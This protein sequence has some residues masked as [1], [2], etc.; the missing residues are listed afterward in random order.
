MTT[1][2]TDRVVE[3]TGNSATTEFSYPFKVVATTD[4]VVVIRTIA[5]G[6]EVTA[7]P[8]TYSVV[9]NAENVGGVVTYPLAG[10]PIANTVKIF[11]TS[12][13]PLTQTITVENQQAYNAN[14]ASSVWDKLTILIQELADKLTRVPLLPLNAGTITFP[15]PVAGQV[16]VGNATGYENGPSADEISGAQAAANAAALSATAAGESEDLA[17]LWAAEDEDTP[18]S[19]GLFSALHYAAKA[20]AS[21]L[22][23]DP[24]VLLARDQQAGYSTAVA[25][26]STDFH[27]ITE[28]GVY[29]LDG[30]YT[31]GPLGSGS[32]AYAGTLVVLEADIVTGARLTQ[33]TYI[34]G[35]AVWQQTTSGTGPITRTVWARL[36]RSDE[37]STDADFEED[38]GLL[39]TRGVIDTE[40]AAQVAAS[41]IGIGQTWQDV[42][43]S[44]VEN[45]SYQNL[46]GKPITVALEI[47]SSAGDAGEFQ[48]STD[49]TTW[50]TVHSFDND[51]S[52][53][54][55]ST[56]IIPPSHYYRQNGGAGSGFTRWV[57]L[58]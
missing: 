37:I 32:F 10:S 39:T 38:T 35:G 40:I 17:A 19:G 1:A 49:D 25:T 36:L 30:N 48:V 15:S 20:A 11:I 23:N 55:N 52:D 42:T 47:S 44:R 45:T 2:A 41:A 58:R 3:Y 8:S 21:A 24:V 6:S 13:T 33:L 31:N 26:P 43:G 14:V 46:T 16:L 27:A 18:V 57:E 22:L 7:D 34:A 56:T 50:V 12:S 28:G 51:A 29:T 4:L 5:D 9:A 53:K 54:D